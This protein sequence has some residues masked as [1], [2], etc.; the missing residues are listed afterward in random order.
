MHVIV[1]NSSLIIAV[2]SSHKHNTLQQ[3]SEK[4]SSLFD[5]ATTSRLQ[6]ENINIFKAVSSIAEYQSEID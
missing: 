3:G 6:F 5:I 1:Y 4:K 2:Q